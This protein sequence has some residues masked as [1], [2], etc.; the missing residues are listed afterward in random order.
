MSEKRLVWDL[1]LRLFH[2]LLVLSIA[3]SWYTA[4]YSEEFFTIGDTLI[5]YAEV[6][7]WLGYWALGLIAFRLIWG[8][9]GPRHAR[10]A[11]FV[12]G[13]RRLFAYAGGFFKRD[14][15]PSVGHNPMG[16]L[17]VLLMLLM[18][19]AQAATGLFLIDNTEIYAAPFHPS[20]DE[21]TANK[22]MSFHQFNFNTL[23]CVICLHVAAILFYRVFKRQRLVGAMITGRKPA[24]FVAV[25]EVIGSSQLWKALIVALVCAGGVYLLL[26]QA[27]PPPAYDEY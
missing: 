23:F 1:P 7:F 2:W 14:S 15:P 3:A 17:V 12:P 5:S 21:A 16:A 9:V 25:H 11:S 6:H 27:P 20:V 22:L 24:E 26:Q 18:V 19:G 4:E 13:P 8:V 10:F